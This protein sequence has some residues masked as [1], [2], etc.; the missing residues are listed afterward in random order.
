M[1]IYTHAVI[2]FS[3]N[4][5]FIWLVY[6]FPLLLGPKNYWPSLAI[7]C[8]CDRYFSNILSNNMP[9]TIT[10]VVMG[11]GGGLI[12]LYILKL[13]FHIHL[14]VFDNN[15]PPP[16]HLIA[17]TYFIFT[18]KKRRDAVHFLSIQR[19]C[20]QASIKSA[21]SWYTFS[22]IFVIFQPEYSSLDKVITSSNI[23]FVLMKHK[24]RKSQHNKRVHAHNKHKHSA[25]N[26]GAL[27]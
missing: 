8:E 23:F 26:D 20:S 15:S 10:T 18:R 11:G 13:I 7:S 3:A 22:A 2:G 24:I 17:T 1:R 9:C 6:R 4:P 21:N 16:I 12:F 25:K 5:I 19:P 27:K 14:F